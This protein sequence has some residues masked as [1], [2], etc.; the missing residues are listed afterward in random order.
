MLSKNPATRMKLTDILQSDWLKIPDEKLAELEA[1][2]GSAAKATAASSLDK[3]ELLAVEDKKIQIN[4]LS[5]RPKFGAHSLKPKSYAHSPAAFGRKMTKQG[6]EKA[7]CGGPAAL[8]KPVFSPTKFGPKKS[9][10]IV[11]GK[12]FSGKDLGKYKEAKGAEGAGDC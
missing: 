6:S 1:E 12:V 3:L 10:T 7:G 8:P 4:S 5:P 11:K 2:A 9:G